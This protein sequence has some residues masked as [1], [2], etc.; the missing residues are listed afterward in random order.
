M[1]TGSNKKERLGEVV[2]AKSAKT[3]VVQTSTRV[4]HAKFGK[5]VKVNRKFHVHDEGGKAQAGDV[6]RIR[7]CRPMSALKRWE[8]VEIVKH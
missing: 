7:E 4:P 3:I 1:V 8:L 5:I 6:V 2:S